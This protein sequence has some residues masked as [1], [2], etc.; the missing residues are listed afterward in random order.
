[1]HC[2]FCPAMYHGF[3][4]PVQ[5]LLDNFLASSLASRLCVHS[6][7]PARPMPASSRGQQSGPWATTALALCTRRVRKYWSHFLVI[8]PSFISPPV[9]YCWGTSPSQAANCRLLL[10]IFGWGTLAKI[11]LVVCYPAPGIV[12]ICRTTVLSLTSC[13]SSRS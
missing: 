2:C 12:M 7:L 13:E 6:S 10:N 9:V 5:I 3:T 1:M 4:R 11:P 8:R